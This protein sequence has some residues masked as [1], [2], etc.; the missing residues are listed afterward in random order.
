MIAHTHPAGS[1]GASAA[2]HDGTACATRHTSLGASV[3]GQHQEKAG[4][5]RN[6]PGPAAE[7]GPVAYVELAALPTTPFWARCQARTVLREWRMRPAVIETA[8]LLVSEL[9]TNADEVHW[10]G[11]TATAACRPGAS[12]AYLPDLT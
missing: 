1:A 2:P 3:P 5:V 11:S 6:N 8:E 7:G 4:I 9:V 10:P 12:G